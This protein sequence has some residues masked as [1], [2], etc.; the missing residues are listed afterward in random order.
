[1]TKFKDKILKLFDL[2]IDETSWIVMLDEF[3]KNISAIG[4]KQK[5]TV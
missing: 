1:M 3:I 4:E 2:E 5:V